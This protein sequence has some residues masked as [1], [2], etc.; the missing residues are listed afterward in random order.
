MRAPRRHRDFPPNKRGV[1]FALLLLAVAIACGSV[2]LEGPI[3]KCTYKEIVELLAELESTLNK[4]AWKR[5]KGKNK[6]KGKDKDKTPGS[7]LATSVPSCI[8]GDAMIWG[9]ICAAR[10]MDR[11]QAWL[12]R[13]TSLSGFNSPCPLNA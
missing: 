11:G 7:R 12:P 3:P 9:P 6:G 10:R 2:V 4:D 1:P 13:N 5:R 8:E